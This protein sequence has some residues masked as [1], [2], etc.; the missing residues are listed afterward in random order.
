MKLYLV[1]GRQIISEEMETDYLLQTFYNINKGDVEQI[2]RFIE[3]KGNDNFILD[4]GAFSMFNGSGK[5]ITYNILK[6][7]IDRYCDF[8]IKY[9]IKNFI[10][11]DVDSVIGY[12]D[13]KKIYKYIENR[14]GRKPLYVHH[15]FTR[16]MED[17]T[18]ACKENDYICYGGIAGI[19]KVDID[20]INCFTDYC[21]SFNTRTHVLG[22]TPPDMTKVTSMYSSDSSSWT[23]GGRSGLIF[24]FRNNHIEVIKSKEKKRISFYNLNNHNLKQWVKYQ[25]YLKNIGW[26]V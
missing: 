10:E 25:Q 19:M 21:K 23:M 22:W 1:N 7:Y 17:L 16:T 15:Q 2:K 20:I 5:K 14:V 12:E 3:R 6:N 8:V 9:K 26:I 18:N 24:Q 11:L 13:V 4:S